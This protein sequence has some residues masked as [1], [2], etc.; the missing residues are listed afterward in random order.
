MSHS[1]TAE[2]ILKRGSFIAVQAAF[3]KSGKKEMTMK[4]VVDIATREGYFT[5]DAIATALSEAKKVGL[6]SRRGKLRSSFWSLTGTASA[7]PAVALE[8]ETTPLKEHTTTAD[9]IVA[10]IFSRMDQLMKENNDLKQKI[11]ETKE[12]IDL[13]E[14][15][16]AQYKEQICALLKKP[17]PIPDHVLSAMVVHGDK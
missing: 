14:D 1:K 12:Y 10:A 4:E 7:I 17:V 15:E 3:R 9:E 16:N 2:G 11:K 8:T 6:T 13:L 5:K